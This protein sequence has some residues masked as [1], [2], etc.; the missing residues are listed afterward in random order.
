MIF[1]SFSDEATPEASVGSSGKRLLSYEGSHHKDVQQQTDVQLW[2]SH[3]KILL[4]ILSS[5]MR[6]CKIGR[7]HALQSV[8]SQVQNKY[9]IS[10]ACPSARQ[11]SHYCCTLPR[12]I[13]VYLVRCYLAFSVQSSSGSYAPQGVEMVQK[14]DVQVW[15]IT[16]DREL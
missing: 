8:R 1:V 5:W 3:L 7:A 13:N 12:S 2:W 11:F 15:K 6:C 4:F 9:I 16:D 14:I 10:C